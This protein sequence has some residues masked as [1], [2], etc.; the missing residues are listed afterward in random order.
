MS[1]DKT[2]RNKLYTRGGVVENGVRSAIVGQATGKKRKTL[3]EVADNFQVAESTVSDT[4]R[5]AKRRMIA[6][7]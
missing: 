4:V 1:M 7:Y 3:A 2:D 5:T 6:K